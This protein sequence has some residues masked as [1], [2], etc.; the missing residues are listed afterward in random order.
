[1]TRIDSTIYPFSRNRFC[2]PRLISLPQRCMCPPNNQMPRS[3]LSDCQRLWW[4]Q[5]IWRP[6]RVSTSAKRQPIC[7]PTEMSERERKQV[8]K[9]PQSDQPRATGS[10]P[11]KTIEKESAL[12]AITGFT[13]I[14]KTERPIKTMPRALPTFRKTRPRCRPWLKIVLCSSQWARII[15]GR[16]LTIAES[17]LK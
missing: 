1:M 7:R 8:S 14:C 10:H 13:S 16:A 4:I 6:L 2:C 9:G 15:G 5:E 17:L 11:K 3:R 12:R